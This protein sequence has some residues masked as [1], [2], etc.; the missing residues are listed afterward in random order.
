[1]GESM[2]PEEHPLI[3]FF[4]FFFKS[5]HRYIPYNTHKHKFVTVLVNFCLQGFKHTQK[6]LPN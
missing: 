5:G 4:F 1:M 6:S 2:T 3:V